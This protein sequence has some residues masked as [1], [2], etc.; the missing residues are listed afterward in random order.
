M[1]SLDG[2]VA[3]ITGS[4]SGL[5]RSHAELLSERGAKI[6]VQDRDREGAEETAASVQANGQD[7]HIMV[8]DVRDSQGY[9]QQAPSFPE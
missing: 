6:I 1:S 7:V 2:R 5:G 9:A 8:G 3:L 4:G